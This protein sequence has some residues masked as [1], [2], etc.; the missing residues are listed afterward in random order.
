MQRKVIKNKVTQRSR[1]DHLSEDGL[2]DNTH[3]GSEKVKSQTI[4]N[5]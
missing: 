2:Q 4:F 5:Y 3:L 1:T